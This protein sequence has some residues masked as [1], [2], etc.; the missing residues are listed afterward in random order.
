MSFLLGG[1]KKRRGF[2]SL[3]EGGNRPSF[4]PDTGGSRGGGQQ[5]M[6]M[7]Q[8]TPTTTNNGMTDM[9]QKTAQ[10]VTPQQQSQGVISMEEGMFVHGDLP[11][12]QFVPSSTMERLIRQSSHF[13]FTLTCLLNTLNSSQRLARPGRAAA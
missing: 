3:P 7:L 1:R 2:A 13:S 5:G 10:L 4:R 8:R 12:V 9:Q 6:V 11:R